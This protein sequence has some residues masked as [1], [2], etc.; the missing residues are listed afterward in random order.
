M[1]IK[2]NKEKEEKDYI[3]YIGCVAS[4][5]LENIISLHGIYGVSNKQKSLLVIHR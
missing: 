3:M 4:A 5:T 1:A 2:E